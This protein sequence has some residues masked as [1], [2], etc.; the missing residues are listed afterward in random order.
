M[1]IDPVLNAEDNDSI[2]ELRHLAI[3]KFISLEKDKAF[4]PYLSVLKKGL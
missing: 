1:C 4:F 3:H 2:A